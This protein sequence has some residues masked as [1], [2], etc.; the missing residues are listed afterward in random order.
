MF[1]LIH[2]VNRSIFALVAAIIRVMLKH[3][4]IKPGPFEPLLDRLAPEVRGC[5]DDRLA[6][7]EIARESLAEAL[8]AMDELKQRAELNKRDLEELN[9]ALK[10][11]QSEKSSVAAELEALKGL[12]V[13]D[14]ETVR[15]ALGVPTTVDRW[16]ERTI[17]FVLGAAASTVATLIWEY[18]LKRLLA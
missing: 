8:N 11:A 6:K 2:A 15:K 5:I 9:A 1:E 14:T 17:S 13:L 4:G 16:A 10:E 12:S 3:Y 18:G 7:I